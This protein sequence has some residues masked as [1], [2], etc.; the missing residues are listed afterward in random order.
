MKRGVFTGTTSMI[1]WKLTMV[2]KDAM[3]NEGIRKEIGSG[4]IDGIL[5]DMA[6]VGDMAGAAMWDGLTTKSYEGLVR[7]T[8]PPGNGA[9][10]LAGVPASLP[11]KN[12]NMDT[13]LPCK[14][15]R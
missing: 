3:T 8:T 11:I 13:Y 6:V 10:K 5:F 9:E 1:S 12:L 7:L 2:V 4:V 14:N 15:T